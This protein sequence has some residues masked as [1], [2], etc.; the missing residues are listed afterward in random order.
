MTDEKLIL[1]KGKGKCHQFV[2]LINFRHGVVTGG[3]CVGGSYFDML[4]G[5]AER[6]LSMFHEEGDDHCGGTGDTGD[7]VDENFISRSQHLIHLVNRPPE[8]HKPF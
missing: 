6:H 7:A 8:I 2:E 3:R 1:T 5:P 4:E